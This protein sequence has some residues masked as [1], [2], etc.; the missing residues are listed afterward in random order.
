MTSKN[1]PSF[2][3]CPLVSADSLYGLEPKGS[4]RSFGVIVQRARW[5]GAEMQIPGTAITVILFGISLSLVLPGSGGLAAQLR[6]ERVLD[7]AEVPTQNT[8]SLDPLSGGFFFKDLP[9][10]DQYAGPFDVVLNKGF[11]MA[12]ASN[13]DRSIFQAAYGTRHVRNS[14]LHPLAS[15]KNT[16]GW[17]NFLKEQILPIQTV[18][19][20]KSGFDWDAAD[21]MTWYP[22]YFGHFIE[23]GITSRRLSEKLRSQGIPM[24]SAVA[25]ATTMAASLINE[26]YT[27]PWLVDG[28]GGT[29]ADL[30]LFDLGGIVIFS[31]DP[32]AGFFAER[33]HAQV[34]PSQA[35]FTVPDFE[36]ANNA[37]NLVFKL[38]IPF[39]DVASMFFRTAVGSHVGATLH[40]KD[41]YDLSIGVGADTTQQKIDPVTGRETVNIR[42]SSSL[43]LDRG[44]SVL[45]SV[46]WS[47]VDHRWLSVNV[48][49]GVL[50]PDFGAWV[51]VSHSG[52]F[53][54]GLTHRR[55]MGLGFGA[56]ASG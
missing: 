21:N 40:L 15:I 5:L 51:V 46:Y 35:A 23:G 56:V 49:P 53:Q 12:Q 44:G 37:N 55:A 43:Y 36:L 50:N 25:G 30:Y 14:I 24:A 45:A 39:I 34:W 54:F 1:L 28:T 8:Q 48:Y 20:I 13:R 18:D 4:R 10:S 27:H 31:L 38:P 33:L 17:G 11:N 32:V 47:E 29:V 42:P 16:G 6:A 41:G 3:I 26:S 19:W 7:E 9:G 52:Q 22:N 2:G